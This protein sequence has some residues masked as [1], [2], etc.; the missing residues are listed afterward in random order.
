MNTPVTSTFTTHLIL[1]GL[2]QQTDP[3]S[4]SKSSVAL[5]S[6]RAET[7]GTLRDGLL[8]FT[9]DRERKSRARQEIPGNTRLPEFLSPARILLGHIPPDILRSWTG[10]GWWCQRVMSFVRPTAHSCLFHHILVVSSQR[11]SGTTK[12]VCHWIGSGKLR[13]GRVCAYLKWTFQEPSLSYESVD[14]CDE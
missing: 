8:L 7:T 13:S 3:N 2:K 6:P 14:E 10:S 9:T 5:I 12:K 1:L 11:L 4:L